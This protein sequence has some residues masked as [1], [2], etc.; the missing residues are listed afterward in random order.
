MLKSKTAK[1]TATKPT[2]K[3]SYKIRPSTFLIIRICCLRF[4]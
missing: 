2:E 1:T 4:V 3:A